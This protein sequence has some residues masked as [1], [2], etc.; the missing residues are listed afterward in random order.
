MQ[1][2]GGAEKM[3]RILIKLAKPKTGNKKRL[4]IKPTFPN[5][6]KGKREKLYFCFLFGQKR[7]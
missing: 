2:C 6:K 4:Q 7:F 3:I 5:V 1:I